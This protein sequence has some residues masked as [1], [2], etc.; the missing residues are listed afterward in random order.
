MSSEGQNVDRKSLKLVTGKT[1][2]WDE[3]AKDCVAFANAQG[4][5]LLLGIEDGEIEPPSG[6]HIPME[7]AE[8]VRKRISELTVNVTAAAVIQASA[9]GGEYLEILIN[10]SHAPASTTDG[11]FYPPVLVL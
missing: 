4:G 1:A 9:S 6:Q 8:K 7:L 3:L 11:R 10:R 2:Q 5:R